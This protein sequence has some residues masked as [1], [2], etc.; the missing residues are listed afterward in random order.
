MQVG[1]ETIDGNDIAPSNIFRLVASLADDIPDTRHVLSRELLQTL[2]SCD[3]VFLWGQAAVAATS[4][5]KQRRG[6]YRS[7]EREQARTFRETN[8]SNSHWARAELVVHFTTAR[9]PTSTS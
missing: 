2:V 7:R 6:G 5:S 3:L 1:R 9:V 4:E 8:R